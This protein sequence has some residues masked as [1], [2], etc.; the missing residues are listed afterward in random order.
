MRDP[1]FQPI[2]INN[3]EVKNRIYMPAMHLGM[4]DSYAVTDKL[5]DFYAERARGGA[6]MI[7]IGFACVNNV[8]GGIWNL[9]GAH[10]DDLVPGLSRI[11]ESIKA[12]GA[13]CA[14]QINHAGANAF[15]AFMDG[16]QPVAPSDVPGMSR[17]TPRSMTS[18]DIRQ[19]IDDFAQAALRVKKAG[20][21]AVEVIGAGGYLISQF[22]SLVTNKRDDEYGG[23]LEN[24]MRFGLEVMQA[25]RQAVKE[26]FPIIVRING[27]E[28]MPGGL[29]RKDLQTFAR[30]LVEVG[31]VDAIN[32]NVGWHQARV[33]QITSSV[34]R[35]MYAYLAK[36]IKQL[37]DVPV[38]ASHRINDPITA[39]EL[40][41][42]GLCDMTAMGR[43]LIADPYF[44]EKARTG[45]EQNI[46]HCIACAQGCF[47]ALFRLAPVE[48][49]CNPKAGHECDRH[50]EKADQPKKVMVIGG[51]PAGM[52]AALA[53]KERGHNVT[54]Y[55]K[56]GRLGG[57]LFLAS[58]PPG[59][60]EF[61]E[62]ANDLANQLIVNNVKVVLN[63]EV[64]L[65]LI[66]NEKPET[67]ILANGARSLTP[68]IPGVDRPNVV[69]A[70]DVLQGSVF[71][72]QRIAVI[73][74]GAVGIE[75][76]LFLA[77]K[78][79]LSPESVKFLLVNK[80]ETPEDLYQLSTRGTKD[81]VLLEMLDRIG[82]DIGK[83]TRWGMIQDLERYGVSVQINSKALEITD[84]GIRV[85]SD[86]IEKLIPVDTVVLAAGAIPDTV[87][88][89]ALKE[90]GID[91]TLVGDVR[92]IGQA[93]D[94][95]HDGF[96]VGRTV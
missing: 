56:Y 73:G 16:K 86:S 75:T 72:G 8:G 77:E 94:A 24:R 27:N 81:I 88:G 48:C 89:Q 5:V 57:Q 6:G 55:E 85:V 60:Q 14:V 67:I 10:R 12:E 59:R 53:A 58:A 96:N 18:H 7:T 32:V 17:E 20:F 71:T 15:S 68:G 82:Q 33:P 64:N 40:L 91:F 23:S 44:P 70:W 52:S 25:V 78:G 47:D 65:Q 51:G 93:F 80:A 2:K 13:C 49:L 95:V 9:I 45:N 50:I 54:L 3:L 87:L 63:K 34:P 28:F 37:V 84:E 36:G 92:K 21:D 11:A 62:L 38:I 31:T 69:Q 22:L 41:A 76:A 1:L 90:K 74:G 29:N 26:D 66:E 35:G 19:T 39:R 79:T 83:S 42:D 46:V 43:G 61:A 4:A 30:Q